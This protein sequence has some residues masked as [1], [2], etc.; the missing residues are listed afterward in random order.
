MANYQPRARSRPL[1]IL[2]MG[3]GGFV[4]WASTTLLADTHHANDFDSA[5]DFIVAELESSGVETT[6]RLFVIVGGLVLFAG[7]FGLARSFGTEADT[8]ISEA[9]PELMAASSTLAQAQLA[10]VGAAELSF[11][12][13]QWDHPAALL[14][15]FHDRSAGPLYDLARSLRTQ[16]LSSEGLQV[17]MLQEMAGRRRKLVAVLGREGAVRAFDGVFQR[18]VGALVHSGGI[19]WMRVRPDLQLQKESYDPRFV[20]EDPTGYLE[21]RAAMKRAEFLVLAADG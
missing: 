1:W 3:L 8:G 17:A 5:G 10:P 19:D 21:L 16:H 7:V 15:L 4:L 13:T 6:R 9:S 14:Y 12:P 18:E 11:D 20:V 2:L